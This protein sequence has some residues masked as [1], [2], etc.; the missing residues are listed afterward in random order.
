MS[1]EGKLLENV[2]TDYFKGYRKQFWPSVL[3]DVDKKSVYYLSIC[4]QCSL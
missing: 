1:T 2:Q 4:V 3:P